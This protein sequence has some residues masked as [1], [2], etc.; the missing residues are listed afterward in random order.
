VKSGRLSVLV[1]HGTKERKITKREM[2]QYDV[3]ITTYGVI[4]SE[5][6][7]ELGDENK[8]AP[9]K[10]EDIGVAVDLAGTKNSKLLSLA[11]ERIILDEAHTIRY[12]AFELILEQ[13]RLQ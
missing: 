13:N 10:M 6:K 2:A 5:V 3:I 12:L 8:L 7:A 11:F 4:L 9:K 1:Y